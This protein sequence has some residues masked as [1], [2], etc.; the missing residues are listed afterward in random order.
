M[1]LRLPGFIKLPGH[2]QFAYKPRIYSPEKEFLE[3]RKRMVLTQNPTDEN[4]LR[5]A[6]SASW[7]SQR[8]R[9]HSRASFLRI[10]VIASLLAIALYI[11]LRA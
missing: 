4:R 10:A 7:R 6:F 3:T 9:A 11:Y 5:E 2:R 1:N 8:R